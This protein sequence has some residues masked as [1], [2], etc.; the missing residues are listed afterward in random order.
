MISTET[1]SIASVVDAHAVSNLPIDGRTLDALVALT[2]GNAT[3]SV[4]NPK[5]AGSMY[6]G[7]NQ[8]SVDGVNVNSHGNGGALYSFATKLST[9]PSIETVQEVK[10][11]ANSARPST[12]VRRR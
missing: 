8:F 6:W 9:L 3:D 12:R 11:E 7:G 1:P 4:N 10:V 5:I 2:P